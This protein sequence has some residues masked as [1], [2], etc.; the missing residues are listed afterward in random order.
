MADVKPS[1]FSGVSAMV[2]KILTLAMAQPR[3]VV[4]AVVVA[5][6]FLIVASAALKQVDANALQ[7]KSASV[8]LPAA[9]LLAVSGI[10]RASYLAVEVNN[11]FLD[12][13][14]LSTSGRFPMLI[15]SM[16]ADFVVGAVVAVPLVLLGLA[17]GLHFATGIGGLVAIIFLAAAWAGVFGGLWYG[18]AIGTGNPALG[19][20][21]YGAILLL[22]LVSP[23][24]VPR[25][26]MAPWLGHVVAVN[27][28]TYL[29][30]AMRTLQSDK[31][32]SGA[33]VKAVI[34]LVAVAVASLGVAFV[35]M[36]SRVRATMA[37]RSPRKPPR[38]KSPAESETEMLRAALEAER[39]A[40]LRL[41]ERLA[42]GG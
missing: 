22:L 27:P 28:V 30:N 40:R 24:L 36:R 32:D 37:S 6:L 16:V 25:S 18:I 2:R 13:L 5:A 3:Q 15:G 31:W 23:A 26:A 20:L 21:E 10:S 8:L 11:G 41:E 33:L 9:V 4:R 29:V 19:P 42:A 1:F 14:L 39:Q 38:A 17:M 34:A 35:T 12:R 7:L